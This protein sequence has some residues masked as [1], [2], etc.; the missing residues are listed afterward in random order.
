MTEVDKERKR[1]PRNFAGGILIG[2]IAGL[3]LGLIDGDLLEGLGFGFIIGL[4]FGAVFERRDHMMH[5]PPGMLRRIILAGGLFLITLIASLE[6][7]DRVQDRSLQ[8]LLAVTPVIGFAFVVYAIGSALASLDELQRRIQTEAIAL[9]FGFTAFTVVG[10]G[11]LSE[12]GLTQPGWIYVVFP[13]TLG[14]GLGKL[15]TMWKYR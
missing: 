8:I 10:V 1:F 7:M 3:I 11:L 2:V 14:W 6:L 15:W 13:M 5:Y 4:A 12:V 9:G